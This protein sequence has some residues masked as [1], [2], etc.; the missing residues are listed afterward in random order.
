[1]QP[2]TTSEPTSFASGT[3]P[4]VFNEIFSPSTSVALWQRPKDKVVQ[5][6]FASVIS[7]LRL[8]IRNVFNINTLKGELEALLPG[9][10]GKEQAIHD[11]H[12]VADMLTCLF[13]CEEVG[14]RLTAIN[15]AMCPR[16]H[17]DDIPVRLIT[18]YCGPGTE[19][20]PNEFA[21]ISKLGHAAGGKTDNQSGLYESEQ[22]VLKSDT[23]DV[24][25]LKGTSWGED[26]LPAIHRS[27]QLDKDEWRV[28]LTLDPL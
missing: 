11:I 22:Q 9:G 12:L 4:M 19:W 25:L 17:V 8:E 21:R 7:S 10:L 5:A 23:F 20:L 13:D 1:M 15:H 6:Y 3:S 16:F 2:Q 24:G 14:L 26:H 27:C 28:V 18:T